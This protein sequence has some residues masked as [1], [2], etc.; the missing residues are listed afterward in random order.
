MT[1]GPKRGVDRDKRRKQEETKEESLTV[2]AELSIVHP[3][4]RTR[5]HRMDSILCA[6]HKHKSEFLLF[7]NDFMQESWPRIL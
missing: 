1:Q 6:A 7:F 5:H 4:K 3:A 2:D